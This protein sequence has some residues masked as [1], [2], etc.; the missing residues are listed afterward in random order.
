MAEGKILKP[1]QDF[2]ATVDEEL[3]SIST[4]PLPQALER[5]T[6]L[7]KQTRQASDAIST[8]RI[9]VKVVQLC[10]EHNAWDTL[11]DEI[12]GFSKKHGQLKAAAQGMVAEAWTILKNLNWEEQGKLEERGKLIETLR[13]VT[14]GKVPAPHLSWMLMCRCLWRLRGRELRGCW[15]EFLRIQ[16]LQKLL[17]QLLRYVNYKSKLMDRCTYPHLHQLYRD[18]D[19]VGHVRKRRTFYLNKFVFVLLRRIGLPPKTWLAK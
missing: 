17:R 3:P 12:I 19:D 16:P 14:E 7:E 5:L 18:I 6:V 8:R 15:L 13:V 11:N 9:L 2:T 1:D 4:L 10:A